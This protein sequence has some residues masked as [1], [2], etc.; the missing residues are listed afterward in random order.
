MELRDTEL[1]QSAHRTVGGR[2]RKDPRI[3][4][5]FLGFHTTL[6][7]RRSRQNWKSASIQLWGL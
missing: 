1:T 5:G 3:F 7:S 4:W 6:W 2:D